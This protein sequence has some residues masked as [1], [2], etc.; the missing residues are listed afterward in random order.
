MS[1]DITGEIVT[2]TN[3]DGNTV[4]RDNRG[5]FLKGVSGNPKGRPD[6]AIEIASR[7]S[8]IAL[9]REGLDPIELLADLLEDA[10]ARE[11]EELR[12]KILSRLMEYSYSK[13]PNIV[14]S[15]V[16]TNIPMLNVI[17]MLDSPENSINDKEVDE[18]DKI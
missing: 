4:A 12:F 14:E 3:K 6:G 11:N 5:R 8:V 1:E 16:E 2:T 18:N 9:Q 10:M 15:K 13:Q 17:G 7:R